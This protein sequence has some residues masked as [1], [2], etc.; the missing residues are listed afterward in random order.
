MLGYRAAV[1]APS[2]GCGVVGLTREV[3][4]A[5]VDRAATRGFVLIAAGLALALLAAWIG[6]RQFISRPIGKLVNAASR[7]GE[8]SFEVRANLGPGKSEIARLGN[9]FG[10]MA[11]A[12]E[13]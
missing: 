3:A 2:S 1:H 13:H 11:S 4:C 10:A 8:G 6:G 9:T 5:S 12:V 7:W